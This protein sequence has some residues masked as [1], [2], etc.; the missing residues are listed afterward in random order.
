[1]ANHYNIQPVFDVYANV[2]DRDLGGAARDVRGSWPSMEKDL[3]RGTTLVLRGQVESMDSAFRGL[4]GGL[5]FAVV[6]VYC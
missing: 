2:Q 1:M 5:V 6:L 4:A 3:P